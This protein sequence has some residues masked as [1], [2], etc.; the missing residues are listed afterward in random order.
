MSVTLWPRVDRLVV[1]RMIDEWFALRDRRE[2]LGLPP[3]PDE[4]FFGSVGGSPVTRPVLGELRRN[5]LELARAHGF[6]ELAPTNEQTAAFDLAIVEFLA[7][8]QP[9][10]SGEALR[11]DVW[12]GVA[13]VLLRDVTAWRFGASRARWYGGTRNTFQR[14]WLRSRTLDLGAE[15]PDRWLLVRELSEDALVQI[16]ERPS[17]GAS[18]RIAQGIASG[19]VRASR[20]VGRGPMEGIMRS[21]IVRIRLQNAV[22]LLSA[23]RSE[24]L[25]SIVDKEFRRATPGYDEESELS[26]G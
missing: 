16:E 7:D 19:W 11:D 22:L 3:F 24:A 6:P 21:A 9:L 26:E 18:P 12:A 13:S 10:D 1:D 25:A 17:I 15:A 23:L 4:T 14:L 8:F 5:V 2:E 20:V